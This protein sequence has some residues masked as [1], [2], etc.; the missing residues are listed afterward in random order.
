MNEQL[1]KSIGK[2]MRITQAHRFRELS[3]TK[4]NIRI[5]VTHHVFQKYLNNFECIVQYLMN[6]RGIIDPVDFFALDAQGQCKGKMLLMTF[7]DGL[8]SSHQA[9]KQI[10]SKYKI[11]AIFFIPT[12]ILEFQS[13]DEMRNFAVHNLY[14]KKRRAESFSWEEFVTMNRKQVLELYREGHRIFPH[15]HT[16]CPLKD[17]TDPMAIEQEIV[18]PKK[19]LE[20]LLQSE[21]NAF[22]FPVGTERVVSS[23]AFP[24]IKREYQYCFSSLAGINTVK[25]DPYFYHRDC[26]HAHYDLDHVHNI[27]EGVYDPYYLYKMFL[28][29]RAMGDRH[30]AFDGGGLKTSFKS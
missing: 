19:I 28:L 11:K 25:T 1:I 26:I 6:K 15:T 23:Y 2:L 13:E 12:Q 20:N 3:S 27:L 5:I 16:H 29:K 9:V 8:L 7:D 21:I 24:Y 17:I 18:R 14:F 30:G 10:L 4:D 22:A